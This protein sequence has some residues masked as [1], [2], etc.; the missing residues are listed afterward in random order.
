VEKFWHAIPVAGKEKPEFSP[1]LLRLTGLQT[2]IFLF[3]Y[4]LHCGAIE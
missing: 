2:D 1:Y 4:W 3:C